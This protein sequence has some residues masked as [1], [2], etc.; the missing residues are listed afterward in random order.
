MAF[1]DKS[2]LTDAWAESQDYMRPLFEPFDEHERLAENRPHPGIA[3]HLPK[4]TEGTLSSTIWKQP[5]RIIQ[6]LPTGKVTSKEDKDFASVIDYIWQNEII[7]NATTNGS[8]L[9]KCWTSTTKA[10]TY[11]SQPTF[12]FFTQHGDY[13]GA[14]F[15]LPYIRDVF[16]ENGQLCAGD[17]NIIFMRDWYTPSQI[18]ALIE[19]EKKL[20]RLAEERGE[21]YKPAWD[22][23]LL[24][25]LKDKTK[26]KEKDSET[27]AE[28]RAGNSHGIE[29]VRA[30][31]KGVGAEFYAF[32]PD[33]DNKTI[34]TKVNPDPRGK[35][36]IIYQYHTVDTGAPL[37][38][39]APEHSGGV[40][41]LL[42]SM[43]Q[44]FQ[45]TQA[46]SLSPPRMKWGNGIIMET[47]Q[48]RPDAL[49]DMGNDANN[50]I[51]AVN[52]SNQAIQNFAN[53]FGLLKS[54]ILTGVAGQDSS[55]SA[56]TG[57]TGFSKTHAG[58]KAQQATLGVDDNY[59]R[60]QFETYFQ[61][62]GETMINIHCA[63]N[64]G[65]E[66]LT[67]E[68]DALEKL[69]GTYPELLENGGRLDVIYD[70]AEDVIKLE[71]E[72]D[73]SKGDDQNEQVEILS[74][75]I[76]EVSNNPVL[77]ERAE[78][79]GYEISI[80]EAFNQKVIASGVNDPEKVIRKLTDEEIKQKQA[81][82]AAAAAQMQGGEATEELIQETEGQPV[83]GEVMEQAGLPEDEG[84]TET[85]RKI[86]IG[87]REKGLDDNTINHALDLFEQG[88]TAGQ[89]MQAIGAV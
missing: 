16:L 14:D 60:K 29:I 58:V 66:E 32:A 34:F 35:L 74:G 71:L 28:Q 27:Q 50:K 33:C 36:P 54:I 56:E 52:I 76:E 39:G 44:A 31:Q 78:Q 87:L 51:E 65:R 41:N 42:D 62:L 63:E 13:F 64:A 30:F 47:V 23:K 40:Q 8:V 11:G 6:Q 70:R 17:S 10:L 1:L 83:D 22:L 26:K 49:W 20:I 59:I 12:V 84:L 43:L 68:G 46:L 55:I 38:R 19:K 69:A 45:Y 67:V 57:A 5:R 18:Q 89:V 79:E 86:V 9:Q 15:R 75:I 3:K 61:E 25:K 85:Q 7:P 48:N 80:G 72:A 4:V 88:A 77:I 24:A 81:D 21:K 37:G 53:N 82:E 73:S 2:N